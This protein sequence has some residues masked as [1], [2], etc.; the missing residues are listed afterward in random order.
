M[1]DITGTLERSDRTEYLGIEL[2]S[3]RIKAVMIGAD[4]APIVSG[5]HDWE[6][7]YENGVWTYHEDAIWSGLQDCFAN[8]KKE[9]QAK[10]NRPLTKLS[11]I[12]LSAMMHGYLAFDRSGKLL[13]PFRTWLFNILQVKYIRSSVLCV[14]YCFHITVFL[15]WPV[16]QSF[17]YAPGHSPGSMKTPRTMAQ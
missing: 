6:N 7:Q 14:N 3:T 11:G 17:F 12:G 16:L 2:G 4:N 9:Y 13:V 8:L 15:F 1:K 10:F 5:S